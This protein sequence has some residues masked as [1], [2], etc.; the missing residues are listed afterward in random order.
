MNAIAKEAAPA[1]RFTKIGAA[2]EALPSD[3]PEWDAVLDNRTGLMWAVKPI[4]VSNGQEKTVLA[5]AKKCQ[6]AGFDDWQAPDIDQL[7]TIRDRTRYSP[8]IDPAYFPDTPCDWFW[9]TTP[10][11]GDMSSG[12]AW[13]VDFGFGY[14]YWSGRYYSGF[15]RAVRVG[16]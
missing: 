16:Q 12:Y 3:A 9:S 10:G 15:V 2:G 8:A 1:A 14:S 5:A 13:V 11:P 4:K 6:A 7:E